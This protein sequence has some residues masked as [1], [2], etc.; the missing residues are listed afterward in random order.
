M[1][2][3]KKNA[4]QGLG[5][6][7]A[8]SPLVRPDARSSAAI[9][10]MCSICFMDSSNLALNLT[11]ST[12]SSPPERDPPKSANIEFISKIEFVSKKAADRVNFQYRNEGIPH[13]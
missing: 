6:G 3:W 12:T 13:H 8:M 7:N 11:P 10:G 4:T 9:V 1:S 2:S 5:S